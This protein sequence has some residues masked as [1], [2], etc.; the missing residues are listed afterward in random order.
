MKTIKKITAILFLAL[1]SMAFTIK[2][3]N[4]SIEP[5]NTQTFYYYAYFTTGVNYET[6]DKVR[7]TP[8]KK[9]RIDDDKYYNITETGIALQLDDY[10]EANYNIDD[11]VGTYGQVF[12]ADTF[13]EAKVTEY[14]RSTLKR[15]KKVVKI[16]DF[17][18]LLERR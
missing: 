7:I 16:Y 14:Y 12:D 15:Y 18:Y 6:Y 17:R 2:T 8:I 3:N 4:G 5:T 9:I 11:V 13:S 1:I 10:V